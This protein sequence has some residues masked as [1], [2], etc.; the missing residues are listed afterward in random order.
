MEPEPELAIAVAKFAQG[1]VAAALEIGIPAL[2][3]D[4]RY[5]D[6][7][8]LVDNLWGPKLIADTDAFFNH[9]DVQAVLAQL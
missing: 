6:V 7:Q 5:A 9:P 2:E 1:D 4:S 8:F 3:K